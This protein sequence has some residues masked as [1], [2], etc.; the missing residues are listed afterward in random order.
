MLLTGQTTDAEDGTLPLSYGIGN[1]LALMLDNRL[2]AF[3]NAYFYQGSSM[4]NTTK[5]QFTSTL[6]VIASTK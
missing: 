2:D 3:D 5:A 4:G 6:G 1:H